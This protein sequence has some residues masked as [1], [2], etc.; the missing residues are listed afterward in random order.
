MTSADISAI[1]VDICMK[2]Y[3]TESTAGV[4]HWQTI[5]HQCLDVALA[6]VN[7]FHVFRLSDCANQIHAN[8]HQLCPCGP[9]GS[10]ARSLGVFYFPFQLIFL[11]NK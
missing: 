9:P 7:V 10:A 4:A 3:R 8:D 5:V 1:S 11:A 2:F 6:T